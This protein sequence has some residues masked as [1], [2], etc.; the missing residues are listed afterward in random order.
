MTGADLQR[1]AALPNYYSNK[2]AL[3]PF[4]RA[5]RQRLT[6]A[7][8][9][10]LPDAL[11]WPTD[12]RAHWRDPS[13]L[14]GQTC[15]YPLVTELAGQVRVVGSLVYD[16]PGCNGVR[17]RSQ[18]VV[19]ADEAATSI[20]QF[21]GRTVA[22][23][24]SDSQSGY[25]ALRALI[26]PLAVDGRFFGRG[27]EAGY[28]LSAAEAVRDGLADIA[29]IDCVSLQ[30]FRR[31]LPESVRGLRVLGETDDFVGLPLITALR[32]DDA[33]LV[34]LRRALSETIADPAN[35]ATCADLLLVGFEPLG[36]EAYAKHLA[37]RDGA[38][39]LG[40]RSL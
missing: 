28:H 21:R 13:L 4:W 17:N 19:R 20:E 33:T 29:S 16:A 35:A 31:Y 34:L 8:L 12:L 26:A 5:L 40:V 23:N 11:T 32:T 2:P 6:Q 22:Y 25:N 30:G 37:M 36:Y 38:F 3:E 24:G 15:G 1:V 9:P 27:I 39:A 10:G 14:L 7:G 18:L